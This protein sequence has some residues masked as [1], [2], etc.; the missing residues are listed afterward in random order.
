MRE[1]VSELR[2]DLVVVLCGINDVVLWLRSD[3]H[4]VDMG[5]GLAEP[6]GGFYRS[7]RLLQF[8]TLWKR[9]LFDDT[10][11][12][13]ID[14][15]LRPVPLDRQEDAVPGAWRSSSPPCRSTGR[16]SARSSPS[17][18]RTERKRSS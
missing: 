12:R 2:P 7:S 16:T 18:G 8:L 4:A 6:F 10:R 11:V 9:V 15:Y 13:I 17:D 5:A 1:V 3:R 14:F